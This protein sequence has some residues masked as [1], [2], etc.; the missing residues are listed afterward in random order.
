MCAIFEGCWVFEAEALELGVFGRGLSAEVMSRCRLDFEEDI[1]TF[2]VLLLYT[3]AVH[4][5]YQVLTGMF[6]KH[7]A[8]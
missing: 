4:R 6:N 5:K 2:Q 3:R 1:Q 8:L 7:P